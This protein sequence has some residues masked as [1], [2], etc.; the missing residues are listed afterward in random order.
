MFEEF[1]DSNAPVVMT[2]PD[3]DPYVTGSLNPSNDKARMRFSDV[4][5]YAEEQFRAPLDFR[6]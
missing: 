6:P 4:A 5:E 1:I 2:N 3:V